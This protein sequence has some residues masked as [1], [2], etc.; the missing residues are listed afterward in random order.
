MGITRWKVLQTTLLISLC[1]NK[2]VQYSS[3]VQSSL[4]TPPVVSHL[5]VL[6]ILLLYSACSHVYKP[7][8]QVYLLVNVRSPDTVT[9]DAYAARAEMLFLVKSHPLTSNID[10]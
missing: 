10:Q 3:P 2:L 8:A 7:I 1:L 5:C 4:Y 6:V 9:L